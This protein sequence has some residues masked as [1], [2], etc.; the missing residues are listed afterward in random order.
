MRRL[1]M[2]KLRVFGGVAADIPVLAGLGGNVLAGM[3]KEKF[4]MILLSF[5][6]CKLKCCFLEVPS[7]VLEN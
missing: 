7:Q 4:I 2:A 1:D 6:C 5:F 3:R